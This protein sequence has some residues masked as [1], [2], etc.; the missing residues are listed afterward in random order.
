MIDLKTV[1]NIHNILIEKF[2]GSKGI[3]DIAG[4][5]AALARPYATFEQMDLY[6]TAQE[7][8][9]ATFESI[10]TNHP[11]ID[12]NKRTA[13]VLMRLILMNSGIDLAGP[14]DEK[15]KMVISA[16]KGEMGFDEIKKWVIGRS[17]RKHAP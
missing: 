14:Q 12:G 13:F 2:G 9:V 11:F 4:L 16:S 3:R 5:E 17:I 10:I 6:P 1:I 8:A 7:K 15:Y